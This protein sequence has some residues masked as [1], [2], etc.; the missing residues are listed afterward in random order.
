[1]EKQLLEKYKSE[2]EN[3]K[4]QISSQLAKIAVQSKKNPSEWQSKFTSSGSETGHEAR[5]TKTDESE[6]YEKQLAVAKI[7][8]QKLSDINVA[9]GKIAN[10]TYGKCE[11]CDC[12]IPAERLAAFPTARICSGCESTLNKA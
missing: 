1:M 6:E 5:E 4:R 3:E 11:N 10:G 7:L 2:L 9:L 12:D 8:A